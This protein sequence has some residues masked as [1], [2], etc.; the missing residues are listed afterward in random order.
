MTSVQWNNKDLY[1]LFENVGLV[2]QIS[3]GIYKV[4]DTSFFGF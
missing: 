1:N 2:T 4:T 3:D